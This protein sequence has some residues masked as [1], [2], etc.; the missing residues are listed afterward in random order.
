M[1]MLLYEGASAEDF[2][3]WPK[4]PTE[5]TIELDQPIENVLTLAAPWES[6]GLIERHIDK[7]I[8]L[9]EGIYIYLTQRATV[10]SLR[11]K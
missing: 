11:R 4:F 10:P 9:E 2:S 5:V 8:D 3:Q 7:S 6:L 1:H